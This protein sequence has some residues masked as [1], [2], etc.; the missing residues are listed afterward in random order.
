MRTNRFLDGNAVNNIVGPTIVKATVRSTNCT[1]AWGSWSPV[2]HAIAASA[3][4]VYPDPSTNGD[5]DGNMQKIAM[6]P[7][8][9][10]KTNIVKSNVRKEERSCMLLFLMD[11]E[12]KWFADLALP[13]G[14]DDANDQ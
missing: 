2:S 6:G 8:I 5:M 11:R 1:R 9:N 14:S 13:K 3:T 10:N 7:A 4:T 12:K